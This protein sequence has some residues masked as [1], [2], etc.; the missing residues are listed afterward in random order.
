M[1]NV[2]YKFVLGSIVCDKD[3]F[4][5]RLIVG[6]LYDMDDNKPIYLVTNNNGKLDWVDA[7]TFENNNELYEG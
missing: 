2:N 7:E 5:Q 1:N 6:R 4:D 3:I